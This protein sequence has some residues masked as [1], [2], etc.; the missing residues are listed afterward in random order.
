MVVALYRWRL[1]VRLRSA[2]LTT[3]TSGSMV[4]ALYH[5]CLVYWL[6]ASQLAL[7][8]NNRPTER[9]Q[10]RSKVRGLHHWY[11]HC[12][13]PPVPACA[14]NVRTIGA[15]ASKVHALYH[16][17]LHVFL[18]PLPLRCGTGTC[19]PKVDMVALS[20]VLAIESAAKKA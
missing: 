11:G 1:H 2:H 17:H 7:R 19:A 9:R 4:R 15:C 18:W 12:A 13:V 14:P 10:T 5:S 3:G 16:K 8:H 6:A 20:T